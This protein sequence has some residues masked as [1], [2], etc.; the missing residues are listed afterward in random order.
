MTPLQE[1]PGPAARAGYLKCARCGTWLRPERL[2]EGVCLDVPWCSTQAGVGKGEL[3][4]GA[5]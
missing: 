5:P 4:G 3:T 1:G 2:T